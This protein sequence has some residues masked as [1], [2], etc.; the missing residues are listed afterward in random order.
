MISEP[1]WGFSPLSLRKYPITPATEILEWMAH[2]LPQCGGVL[3]QAE[4][5]LASINMIMGASYGGAP[6]LTAT[7]SSWLLFAMHTATPLA[8]QSAV[9]TGPTRWPK[10]FTAVWSSTTTWH[11]RCRTWIS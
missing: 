4:D 8:A 2:A 3:V 10:S 7:G 6:S 11:A 1:S 5:E 9:P